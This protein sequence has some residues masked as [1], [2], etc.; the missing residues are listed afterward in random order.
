MAT[1]PGRLRVV[2]EVQAATVGDQVANP[3]AGSLTIFSNQNDVFYKRTSAGVVTPLIPYANLPSLVDDFG[4]DPTGSVDIAAAVT[5]ANASGLTAVWVPE[6]TYMC[7]TAGPNIIT[8]HLRFIGANRKDTIFKTNHA[9]NT[10]FQFR[11]WGG[12]FENIGVDTLVARTGGY[13][14]DFPSAAQAGAGAG[15]L[16]CYMR[17]CDIY[18]QFIAMHSG[19]HEQFFDDIEVRW[20]GLSLSGQGGFLLDGTAAANDK[21]LFN[22]LMQGNDTAGQF[23]IRCTQAASLVMGGRNDLIDAGNALDLTPG[24]GESIPSIYVS[25]TFFDNSRIGV[26]IAPTGTGAVLRSKF[27][28]SW[29]SSNS[30]AGVRLNSANIAGVDF[31]GCDIFGNA[32]GIEALA[33][34][35]WSVSRSRIAGNTTAGI[36]ATAATTHNFD[37]SDNRFGTIASPQFGVNAIGVDVLAGTYGKY[38]VTGNSGLETDTIGI[39]DLGVI[40]PTG[41]KNVADNPGLLCRGYTLPALSSA[42]AA[43]LANNG[44]GAV[45]SGTAKT[46][47]MTFRIPARAVQPGQTFRLRAFGVT[48]GAGVPTWE[49]AVGSAGTTADTTNLATVQ[50]AQAANVRQVFEALVQVINLSGA[51]NVIVNGVVMGGITAAGVWVNE[52]VAA[53]VVASI[54]TTGVWFITLSVTCGT[55]GTLTIQQASLEVL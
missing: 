35:D 52:T 38:L 30:I 25:N 28:E 42:G 39:Q 14:A 7:A 55:T 32:I 19:D 47:M 44:R 15:A 29:M 4:A 5:A 33:A 40:G 46:F 2:K 10:A 27:V 24:N 23:G 45:T 11:N 17:H 41:F 53:E 6:G 50:G 51:S 48:S 3:P 18:N 54:T 43:L 22:I 21:R 20:P 36:R 37:V 8:S 31:I 9:S 49:V 13:F 1:I 26:N 34:Q 12:G 16:Y